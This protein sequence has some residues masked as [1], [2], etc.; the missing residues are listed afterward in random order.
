MGTQDKESTW[1]PLYLEDISDFIVECVDDNLVLA[2]MRSVWVD[3]QSLTNCNEALQQEP[4]YID[5]V[6]LSDSKRTNRNVLF[7]ISFPFL[8][9]RSAQWMHPEIKIREAVFQQNYVLFQM[10]VFEFFRFYYF[11]DGEVPR[12]TDY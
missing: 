7:L 10:P 11:D 1:R 3:R 8:E 9:Y 6:L 4:T 2:V 5:E 12:G